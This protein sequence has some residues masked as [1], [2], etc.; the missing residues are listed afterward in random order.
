ME[1]LLHR[2]FDSQVPGVDCG[3]ATAD[4]FSQYL[5]K[6]V[7]L[8]YFDQAICDRKIEPTVGNAYN[9]QHRPKEENA[10]VDIVDIIQFLIK[11]LCSYLTLT[12]TVFYFAVDD[13]C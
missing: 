8:L 10:K 11:M 9:R 3:P 2:I 4:W 13:V 6:K 7:K 12:S 1:H 5:N